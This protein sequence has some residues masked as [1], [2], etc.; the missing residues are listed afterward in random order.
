MVDWKPIKRTGHP[1]VRGVQRTRPERL[2][3][4]I[5]LSDYPPDEWER[6]FNAKYQDLAQ[7]RHFR[8][9]G[10]PTPSIQGTTIRIAPIDKDLEA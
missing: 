6:F 9:M 3:V 8:E 1:D 4:V 10:V 7:R 5:S 2:E